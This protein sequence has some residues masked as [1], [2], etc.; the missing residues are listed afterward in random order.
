[1]RRIAELPILV[2]GLLVVVL[3][4]ASEIAIAAFAA[5][6]L[7]RVQA[8]YDGAIEREAEAAYQLAMA[9][10]FLQ[11]VQR[12]AVRLSIRETEAE[13]APVVARLTTLMREMN[14][15]LEAAERR[16]PALRARVAEARAAAERLTP[17]L[18]EIAR[19]ARGDAPAARAL[20]Q[21]MFDPASDALR[22]RLDA[23]AVEGQR[24]IDRSQQ[25]AA[26]FASRTLTAMLVVSAVA[27]LIGIVLATLLFTLGVT[28]PMRA[29]G[30]EVERVSRGEL[31]TPV[32]GGDR[33]DEIGT[34]ARAVEV[35]RQQGLEKRRIEAEAA[36]QQAE[37]DRR[38]GAMD[39]HV[40]DF[41]GSASAVM[42]SVTGSAGRMGRAAAEM[43]ELTA[44]MRRS[45][46][47]VG[48]DAEASSADLTA[49]AAA[50]EELVASIG[51]IARQVREATAAVAATAEEAARGEGRMSEL[52]AA[53]REIGE[54][55]RLIEDVAGRTNLLALNATIEAARAGE[56]GKGF[57]VVAQEVKALAAQTGKA[58]ADIAARIG[59]VQAGAEATG[60]AIGRIGAEV[61]RVR[62]I[63]ESIDGAV[64]QQGEA[65]REIAVK[66]AQV[67][68]AS[69]AAARAMVEVGGLADRSD[70]AGRTVL[71]ASRAV[72][73]EARNLGAELDAFLS[74]M[75]DAEE[76]RKYE[77]I[78]GRD[79]PVSVIG[80]DVT[81]GGRI[82]DISR[83]GVALRGVF[84]GWP[85]GASVRIELP[86]GGEAVAARLVRLG[87][88]SAAFAFRQDPASLT[89][90]DACLERLTRRAA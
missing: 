44:T 59:A 22:D 82:A 34:L 5:H 50:T 30:A 61:G 21:E 37:K 32:S 12:H 38:Q 79:A 17:M 53:A 87:E 27:L 20:V 63:A 77:R 42:A 14:S 57:A 67:V 56:A 2:K 40:Q 51:E 43:A 70:A 23:L 86:G 25:A 41:G 72:E 90:I 66:V 85:A 64:S 29:L 89:V 60:Q 33:R 47:R 48:Q 80:S 35:F 9:S 7:N 45:A 58:T 78:D 15:A 18:P 3:G 10:R 1:M 88:D 6:G 74:T 69:G 28:R 83:G 71:D 84:T 19:L 52:G 11:G 55:V 81:R 31:D 4:I 13:Q 46:E 16:N 76:R 73:G 8:S 49:A 39:R 65:T 62:A 36:R 75:R 26:A 68:A 54:V 24:A